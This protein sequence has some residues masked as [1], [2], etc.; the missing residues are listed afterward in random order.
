ML[1][2]DIIRAWK[3]DEYRLSLSDAERALLPANPAG[4]IDL[5]DA[6]LGGVTGAKPRFTPRNC[7][8]VDI[9]CHVTCGLN[10]CA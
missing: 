10:G 9:S 2:K 7:I 5:D 4:T 3:D 6:E 8:S 1:A